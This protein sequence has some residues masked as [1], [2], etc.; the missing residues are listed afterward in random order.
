[1]NSA[2][3][4]QELVWQVRGH[5]IELFGEVPEEWLCWTPAGTANTS[6]G[7]QDTR[8]GCKTFYVSSR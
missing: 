8:C 2:I 7:M 5:T 4:L 1:M 3:H 6:S